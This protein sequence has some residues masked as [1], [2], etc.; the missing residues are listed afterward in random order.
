MKNLL[1]SFCLCVLISGAAAAQS[2]YLTRNAKVMFLSEAPLEK[3]EA[4]NTQGTSIF[5]A[6]TGQFECAI[7]MKAFEFEKA[8][9]MEHFNENYVESDKYPKAVFK[10]MITDMAAVDLTKPGSYPVTFKG[11][12][13]LHGVKKEISGKGTMEIKDGKVRA[14]SSFNLLLA[15]FKIEIPPLVKDKVAKEVNITVDATYEKM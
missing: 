15:D 4:I 13:D 10:G 3:I 11:I 7:L 5:V 2:K 1:L 8:L 6:P 9:M 12:M 14:R